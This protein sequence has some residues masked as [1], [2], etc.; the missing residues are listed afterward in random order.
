MVNVKQELLSKTLESGAVAVVRRIEEEKVIK[1]IEALVE[2]G[3]TGIEVTLDSPNALQTIKEAKRLFGD[4]AVIGAGTVLDGNA[5]NLAIQHGADF[6]FA[7]TLS[8]ET[9]AVANRYGKIAIPGVFTPTEILQAYE[10]GAD[11]VKVFPASVLGSQFIKDVRGPLGHIP[12]MPTGGINLDNVSEY[13]KAGAVAAG[14]GGSLLDKNFIANNEW[15]KL[16]D[17]AR[18]YVAKIA[19][20]RN[21]VS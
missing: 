16:A 8:Q 15:D 17:L 5:A 18:Q 2:G 20:A 10:W 12:M 3:I 19:E 1:A 7:P 4:K 9:I 6:I 13:I 11:V 21:S 14:I